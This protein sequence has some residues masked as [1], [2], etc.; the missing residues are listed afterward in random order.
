[1]SN[2][3]TAD[4][5]IAVKQ[6]RAILTSGFKTAVLTRQRETTQDREAKGSLWVSRVTLPA[7]AEDDARQIIF[8]AIETLGIGNE[9]YTR[10]TTEAVKAQ[11][12]GYRAGVSAM[13]PEPNVSE[14]EK[15][16]G[17]MKEVEC[18]ITILYTYGG[19]H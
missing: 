4:L 11:W 9:Q 2:P 8:N 10:P 1:M 15:F 5:A 14:A 6:A 17:L 12:T 7:P 3:S 13:E 18:P 19:A 16:C